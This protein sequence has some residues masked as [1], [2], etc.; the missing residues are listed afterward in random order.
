MAI[1]KGTSKTIAYKKEVTWGTLVT[2]TGAKQ[3]RRVTGNFNL[4]KE[5][6]ESG[7]IRTD[8]QV[9]D[10]RHGV[11]S[12]TGSLNGEMSAN[13]YSDFMQSVIAK[14]FAV[15][16]DLTSLSFALAG[17]TLGLY[18]LTRSSGSWLSGGQQVGQ[19]V[20]I[21]TATGA[22]ADNLNKNLLI[23]SMTTLVL[24]V[25]VVNNSVMT[26]SPSVTGATVSTIGKATQIPATGHTEDS[27]TVE[28]FYSDIAQSE[29]YSGV[30][31][32]TMN[33]ALPATGLT[34]VDF[35]FMGKDLAATGTTQYFTSPTVQG[36]NGILASVSGVMLVNGAPVAL[37]TS[38]DFAVE[39]AMENATAVGSNSI[40]EIFSGRIRVTGNL[41]V[42][43][44]DTVFRDYFN[45]ESLV[46]VV[47]V[48]ATNATA[49]SDFVS[50]T[51]PSVKL[52]SFTKDDGEL[53]LVSQSSFTALLNSTTG[54]GLPLSTFAVQ[55]ST[56][57]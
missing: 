54:G 38:A 12:A 34:T 17:P 36:T 16:A 57:V 49:N 56:L 47:M 19:V 51:M 40:A 32:G 5:T 26:A 48:L 53:G 6:Y 1:S 15:V 3:L 20:R 11:R 29:V 13:T 25:R 23:A 27:Y 31:V 7:E 50:F 37:I 22:A 35:S 8:R 42:Y 52:G 41:S 28:E 2:G 45:A 10:F 4:T 55:D 43:F 9:A 24:T 30:K 21:T 44:Q 33:V 39:R 46:S 18:T 14:D